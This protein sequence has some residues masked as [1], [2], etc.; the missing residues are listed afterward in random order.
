M[1]DILKDRGWQQQAAETAFE[2]IILNRLFDA[3]LD[4]GLAI[5]EVKAGELGV[6]LKSDNSPVTRAD[7]AAHHILTAALQHHFPSIPIVSEED[8]RGELH[9]GA[10]RYFL[11]DPLDGTKEFI[12]PD[13]K[14][15]FTV[16]IGLIDKNRA[17]AG[18]VLAPARGQLFWGAVG[19]A[20][21]LCEKGDISELQIPAPT[22]EADR[23][24][25]VAI[26]SRSHRDA[27]T[28]RFLS[29]HGIETVVSVG[30][31]LKF[32]F[33]AMGRADIYPRFGPTMEWD[34]A[35]G[36]AVLRA[37]GGT[38]TDAEG[39][40]HLYGKPDRLNGPFIACGPFNPFG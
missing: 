3:V 39:Q 14:G 4:A 19:S 18:I 34:T 16:N 9:Q 38:V 1:T 28:D 13:S 10:D 30:S 23:T 8:E 37:A 27:D 29:Q 35:A 25:L 7:K 22:S 36:E 11:V 26:A 5:L 15:A 12:R 32:G 33:V 6:E 40:P 2:G 17:V 31:S 20:S 24:G 21:Y